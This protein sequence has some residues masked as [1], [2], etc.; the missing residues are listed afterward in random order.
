MATFS[1]LRSKLDKTLSTS[2]E[3]ASFADFFPKSELL[4][5][6]N[7]TLIDEIRLLSQKKVLKNFC[8]NEVTEIGR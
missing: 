5:I 6:N 1:L 7:F 2:R 8:N 4:F 3:T